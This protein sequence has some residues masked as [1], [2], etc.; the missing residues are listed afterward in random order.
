MIH[1]FDTKEPIAFAVNAQTGSYDIIVNYSSYDYLKEIIDT[2]VAKAQE[3]IQENSLDKDKQRI[4]RII[5]NEI[6]NNFTPDKIDHRLKY[7]FS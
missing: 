1:Y 6:E 5:S 3:F 4:C 7:S 2:V